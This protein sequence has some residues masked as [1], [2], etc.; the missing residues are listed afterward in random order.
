M[1]HYDSLMVKVNFIVKI[2]IYFGIVYLY[3]NE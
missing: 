1:M 2:N 3:F